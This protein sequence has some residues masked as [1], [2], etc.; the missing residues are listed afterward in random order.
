MAH[1]FLNSQLDLDPLRMR[2]C[3]DEPG[4][5]QT[6]FIQSFELLQADREEFSR[7]GLGDGPCG[8]WREEAIAV[9]AEVHGG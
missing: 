5:D 2:F 4:V 9:A 3:P 8:G 1:L 7:F 6:D